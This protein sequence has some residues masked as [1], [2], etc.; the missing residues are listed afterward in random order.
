MQQ[1]QSNF[2]F[3]TLNAPKDTEVKGV[4]FSVIYGKSGSVTGVDFPVLAVS[5]LDTMKGLSIPLF[6]PGGSIINTEMKGVTLGVFTYNKGMSTGLNANFVNVTGETK[7]VNWSAVN[8]A[9]GSSMVDLGALNVSK[10][11]NFQL[12]VVN[13]TEELNGL[14]IGLICVAKNGFLPFFIIFN[15]GSTG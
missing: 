1:R 14:Q 8:W 9:S 6:L 3:L 2:H 15:F 4:R 5:E 13:V 11:G 7:G 12:G 10:G